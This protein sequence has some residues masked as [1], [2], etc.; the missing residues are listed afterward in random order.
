MSLH[1]VPR[2]KVPRL[3]VPRLKD[4][5]PFRPWPLK[6]IA[7][8]RQLTLDYQSPPVSAPGN[9]KT[10]LILASVKTSAEPSP[11]TSVLTSISVAFPSSG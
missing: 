7:S 6:I 8:F 5:N 4:H 2:L 3:K 11:Q 10:T 9:E 1:L